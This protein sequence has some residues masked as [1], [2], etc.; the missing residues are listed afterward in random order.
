MNTMKLRTKFI[1]F[2]GTFLLVIA[3]GISFYAQYIVGGI[4]KRQAVSNLRI[5]AEQ[6]ESAYLTF[7]ETMKVRVV[8]WTSDEALRNRAKAVMSSPIDS[9]ERELATKEF[10]RYVVEKKMP[11]DETIFITDLLD[12]DGIV[13]AS[14]QHER[15]GKN[16]LEEESEHGKVHD[17]VGTL[18]SKFGDAF[19]GTIILDKDGKSEP[20]ISVTVRLFEPM[21]G[22]VR[23]ALD[24]VLLVYYSYA[25][26]PLITG[27]LTHKALLEEYETSDL[28]LVNNDRYMVTPSRSVQDVKAMQKVDTLPVQECLE[29]GKEINEEYDNYQG[30]R[31]LGASM[32]FQNEGM[33]VLA[34][35]EKQEIFE[36]L[37]NLIRYTTVVGTTAFAF[38]IF[39]IILF[40]RRSLVRIY[41][42][43]AVAKKVESGDLNAS[44]SSETKDE[45]GYLSASFN[46]MIESIRN[47]QKDLRA[48][49]Y[50]AEEEKA[51]VEALLASLGEG[52][53]ATDHEGKLI[54]MNRVAEKMLNLKYEEV[55][56]RLAADVVEAIEE[57]NM[58][59]PN[60]QRILNIA[61]KGTPAS[62]NT[63]QYKRKGDGYFP[64]AVTWTPVMLEGRVT[65]AVGIFR[66][67]TK[68][69]QI[70]KT[71]EDLLSLASHQLRTPLSG[72]KWLI[73]TLKKGIHGPLT[74]GQKEYIDELYKINERMTGLV[75][76]MLGV[77][78]LEGDH[79]KIKS[80]TVSLKDLLHIVFETLHG[81]A[82]SKQIKIQMPEDAS[83]TIN[84]DPLLLR[85]I[86]ESL[87]GNAINY[88]ESGREVVVWIEQKPSEILFA[89]KDSGIGIPKAEQRQ[90]F[91]RFYRASNAK[92][93]DTR[94]SGLGLYIASMLAKKIGAHLTFESEEGKGSTFYVHLPSPQDGV[95]PENTTSV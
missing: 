82:E 4:F 63:V 67:I 95:L 26:M 68:E 89:V 49:K 21:S 42:I 47:T 12:K 58:A 31:V 11:F 53:I 65:G 90:I 74:E 32:C 23:E 8:D 59:I 70:E 45:L 60:E 24:L 61:L 34:E 87:V 33:V 93:F 48:S 3:L 73:E 50:K 10:G 85:N 28:Y 76:D 22:G 56:G 18:N 20:S 77:L 37:T 84:T 75:H 19:F 14:S 16:E 27:R 38:G 92:T 81:I 29:N 54:A 2:F 39:I 88:S 51:K 13:I 40:L 78:R 17:I 43:V 91:E 55:A 80:E 36:P 52:M 5:I 7:L 6:S 41:D 72:T 15:I 71:R 9:K 1:L 69:K 86:L 79:A 46:R 62:L 66:D 83:F 57:N 25:G 35:V 30:V 94:G 64:V 44:I